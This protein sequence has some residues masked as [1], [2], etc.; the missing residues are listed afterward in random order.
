MMERDGVEVDNLGSSSKSTTNISIHISNNM[1]EETIDLIGD[2]MPKEE[3][4]NCMNGNIVYDI[5]QNTTWE[6]DNIKSEV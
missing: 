4:A 3:N 6:L 2:M 5:Y 1:K